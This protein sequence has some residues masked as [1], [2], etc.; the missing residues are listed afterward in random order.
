LAR[1]FGPRGITIN[2]VQPGPIDTD[3]N[4]EDGPMKDLMHSFMAIKRHGRPE[5]VAGMVSWLAGPERASSPGPC[6]RSMAR[7]GPD[8]W[9]ERARLELVDYHIAAARGRFGAML[10]IT[11]NGDA[12][13]AASRLGNRLM[14]QFG[15][16]PIGPFWCSNDSQSDGAKGC[17][18][19][20]ST[21]EEGAQ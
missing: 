1:D 11:R 5:E 19:R 2:I 16:P 21:I 9:W 8:G 14:R 6:T 18:D 15:L 4:P 3:S 10:E 7:S 12:Q 17:L 13:R 20:L